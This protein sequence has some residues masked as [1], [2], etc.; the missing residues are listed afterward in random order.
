MAAD[1]RNKNENFI[2]EYK[3]DQGRW[4]EESAYRANAKT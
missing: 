3:R 4:E 1:L 2:L